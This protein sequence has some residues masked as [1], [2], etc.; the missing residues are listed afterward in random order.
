MV[1]GVPHIAK[2][3]MEDLL[4]FARGHVA[5]GAMDPRDLEGMCSLVMVSRHIL[6]AGPPDEDFLC[7]VLVPMIQ[8]IY[9]TAGQVFALMHQQQITG[10][11]DSRYIIM[12]LLIKL[13]EKLYMP[14]ELFISES[15]DPEIHVVHPMVEEYKTRAGNEAGGANERTPFFELCRSM[16][17]VRKSA[18]CDNSACGACSC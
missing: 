17:N 14:L 4:S 6:G 15:G 12:P 16:G 10:A 18:R 3:L 9:L 2:V 7:D 11:S 13:L 8:S 1:T 5:A